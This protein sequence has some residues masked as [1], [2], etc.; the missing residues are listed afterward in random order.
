MP[1]IKP[2]SSSG[3]T[4]HYM[5]LSRSTIF[6]RI[7]WLVVAY[8][9]NWMDAG[10]G[11]EASLNRNLEAG[12]LPE[13]WMIFP[14]QF[15][16]CFSISSPNSGNNLCTQVN[17]SFSFSAGFPRGR[18]SLYKDRPPRPRARTVSTRV[19]W[20]MEEDDPHR[21][22]LAH[23]RGRPAL[24]SPR[25]WARTTRA[26]VTSPVGEDDPRRGHLAR[27]RGRPA[28][29]SPRPWA[30]TTRAEVTSPVGEDDPRRGHLARGRGRPAPRSPRPWAM[31]DLP[32]RNRASSS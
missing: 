4:L 25:A 27:G 16:P 8:S 7:L 9:C 15:A 26:E 1:E 11:A 24:R 30:R 28:P 31:T 12:V 29:R 5:H 18:K 19:T 6:D 3:S 21:G 14:N 17:R 20:P 23:G 32:S 2:V 22:H 13:A 10:V